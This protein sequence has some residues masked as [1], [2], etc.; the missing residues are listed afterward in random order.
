MAEGP[1]SEMVEVGIRDDAMFNVYS[2]VESPEPTDALVELPADAAG[3][4][5]EIHRQ[6]LAAQLF[7]TN[8]LKGEG[9]GTDG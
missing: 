1:Q 4:L 2:I 9:D 6:F 3:A 5:V 7:L 8:L